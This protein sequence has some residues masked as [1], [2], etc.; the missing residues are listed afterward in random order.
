VKRIELFIAYGIACASATL[1]S[2][3]GF[4]SASG[5]YGLAKGIGLCCVA[6]VGC[7]GPAW[8]AKVKREMGWPAAIFGSLATAACLGVTLY[9]GLGT[10]AS[11]GA[12][13][14]AESLK[15]SS[16]VDRDR[17]ALKR[18]AAERETMRF[19]ATDADAVRAAQAA[20][21]SAEAIRH[22]ECGN[23]DPKQRGLNCRARESEE[24]AK[25]DALATALAS[26]ALTDQAARLDAEIIRVSAKL[27]RAPPVVTADPQASTFSQLTGFSV[28]TSAALYAFLFSIALETAAM[29][30]MLVAY[31]SSKT[32]PA[33]PTQGMAPAAEKIEAPESIQV[34]LPARPAPRLVS[35][36]KPALSVTD[37]VGERITACN[38]GKVAFRD[39]YLDYEAVAQRQGR[40]ALTPEQFTASPAKLCEGTSVFAREVRGVVFLLNVRLAGIAKNSPRRAPRLGRTK[41]KADAAG[42]SA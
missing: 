15:V 28:D 25:R 7:H 18:L 23:G 36:Q 12:D 30:A 26:K 41:S 1:A 2:L 5:Y 39:V 9:G 29:F 11:G 40:P 32:S 31:S 21:A 24:Q 34:A 16:T 27:D 8:I 4:M 20:V 19:T 17:A 3:Y 37:Y 14:R 10:I 22:R 35:D 38:G 6:F 33:R 42:E 13:L